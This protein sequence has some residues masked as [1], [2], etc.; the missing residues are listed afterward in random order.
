MANEI[1]ATTWWGDVP[2]VG[3]MIT[4]APDIIKG[5]ID[6]YER[7]VSENGTSE[8]TLCASL[9]LHKIANL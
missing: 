4:N 6:S 2:R 3:R 8:S 7:A 1:Y 5:Q 9:K